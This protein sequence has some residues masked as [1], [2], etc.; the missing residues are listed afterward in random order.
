MM[1]MSTRPATAALPPSHLI[2]VCTSVGEPGTG[3]PDGSRHRRCGHR[4]DNRAGTNLLRR[5]RRQPGS[6]SRLQ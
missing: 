6:E 1:F 5:T 2:E 3:A 4:Q